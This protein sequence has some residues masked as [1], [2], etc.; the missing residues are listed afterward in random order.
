MTDQ[1]QEIPARSPWGPDDEIGRLN[2]ITEQSRAAAMEGIDPGRT[3]DLGVDLYVG[4]PSWA[5]AGDPS[6]MIWMTHTP[7]GNLIDNPMKRSREENERVGYS[8]D[9]IAMYTHCGTHLDTLN[10]FSR[11]GKIWNGFNEEEHLGS[12]HWTKCGADKLPPIVARGVMLDIPGA[13]GMDMLPQGHAISPDEIKKAVERQNTPLREGDVVLVR[14]GRMAIYPDWEQ[15]MV[16]SPG[17]S[18]DS[19]KYLVEEG[20]AI[21]LGADNVSVEQ[22]PSPVKDNW[23]P[24]HC[25]CFQEVGVCL[26]EFANLEPLAEAGVYEF[27]FIGTPLK[28]RGATGAPLR[29]IA[30]AYRD[31]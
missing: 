3:F 29:P 24:V 19:A 28:I 21:L 17:I 9:S 20:G 10:H 15:F 16:N 4:M 11:Y 31:R 13:L 14:T 12:R 22:A 2:L 27:C 30:M 26:L 1:T 18:L 7:S 23:V 8:G 6:F 25:Y 5:A